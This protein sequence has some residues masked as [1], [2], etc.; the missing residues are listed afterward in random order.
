MSVCVYI[1]ICAGLDYSVDYYA[2]SQYVWGHLSPCCLDEHVQTENKSSYL[3]TSDEV[4]GAEAQSV[5]LNACALE[6]STNVSTT[7]LSSAVV[8]CVGRIREG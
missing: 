6:K 4:Y 3:K 5:L 8:W 2:D 1:Q 7:T